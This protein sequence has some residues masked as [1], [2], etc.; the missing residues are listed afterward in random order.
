MTEAAENLLRQA[1][2]LSPVEKAELIERLFRSFDPSGD[3]PS[4]AAW[5]EEAESRIDA[6]D[7]GK[8]PGDSADA[9]LK[10]INRR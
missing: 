10:R 5:A 3:R 9:V 8:I 4:D 6:C 2:R 7:A 1:I